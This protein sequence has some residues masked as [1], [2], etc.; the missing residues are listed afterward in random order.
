MSKY[1]TRQL[2]EDRVVNEIKRKLV[3]RHIC[4]VSTGFI[5]YTTKAC[6]KFPTVLIAE[7]V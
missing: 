3:F 2:K 6:T 4:H 1:N 5:I 7:G